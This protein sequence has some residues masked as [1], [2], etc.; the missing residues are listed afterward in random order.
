VDGDAL[1]AKTDIRLSHLQLV[2]AGEHDEAQKRIGL[3]LGV[4]TTLMKNKQGDINLSLPVGGRLS[5]P[6]FDYSEALWSSIRTVSINAIKLPVSW[7]GRVRFT[8]DSRIERID[9][10]PVTFEAGTPTLTAE[11]RTQATRLTAFLDELPAVR[12]AMTPVVSSRDVTE[13]KRRA[14]EAAIDRVARQH[15]LAREAAAVR[16]F[17]ERF[18]DRPAPATTG[19]ALAALLEEAEVAPQDITDLATRRLEAVRDTVKRAGL[20]AERLAERKLVQREG[21]DGQ[22][23]LDVVES[24]APRPSKMREA[25]SKLGMPV[26]EGRGR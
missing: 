15:Q 19:A 26:K 18:P 20:P 5:D 25:L 7:I 17:K 11:G 9:I 2:R 8:R 12:L 16:V 24:E 3:P 13:L 21:R 1:S 6:R 10:D 14:A 4:I 23:D 22:V